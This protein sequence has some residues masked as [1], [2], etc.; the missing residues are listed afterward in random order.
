MALCLCNNIFSSYLS[1]WLDEVHKSNYNEN[2]PNNYEFH[3]FRYRNDYLKSICLCIFFI[4][5]KKEKN[6]LRYY[7]INLIWKSD[8]F[9]SKEFIKINF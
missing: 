8:F 3:Y 5:I 4:I 2:E 1:I 9:K 7:K 6:Y